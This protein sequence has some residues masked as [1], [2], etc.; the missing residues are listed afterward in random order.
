M[1]KRI[2]R[3]KPR[4]SQHNT[5]S[6]FVP[7]VS[8]FLVSMF[9]VFIQA[10]FFCNWTHWGLHPRE[11]SRTVFSARR[12]TETIG[13]MRGLRVGSMRDK[14][15]PWLIYH[16]IRRF[17]WCIVEKFYILYCL[18]WT[19][20]MIPPKNNTRLCNHF[21]IDPWTSLSLRRDYGVDACR[22]R[23]YIFMILREYLPSRQFDLQHHADTVLESMRS[24]S[25]IPWSHT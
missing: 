14:P 15:D 11:C 6:G 23:I 5:E 25:T 10:V 2:K 8:V 1:L 7:Q 3:S 19:G 16:I 21:L 24:T 12:S 18:Y 22:D 4:V 17:G 9:G 13:K 20:I